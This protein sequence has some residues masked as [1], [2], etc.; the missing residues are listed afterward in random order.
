M[1]TTL[2]LTKKAVRLLELCEAEGF[3]TPEDLLQAS[4]ADS[5]CPAICMEC[6]AT[7]QME[8]DQREGYCES[9]G[10]NKVVSGLVLAGLI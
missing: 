8:K 5:V 4:M 7:A 9:C 6:G 2:A 3:K 1:S 10:K